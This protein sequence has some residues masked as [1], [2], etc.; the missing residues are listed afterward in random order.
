LEEALRRARAE[1]D[2]YVLLYEDEGTFYRQP[3]QGWLW[4]WM[5]RSQPKMRY[6][7]AANRRLRMVAMLNARTGA[8]H[9][10]DMDRVSALRLARTVSR[11]SSWYPDAETIYLGWDN[12][13]VHTH[14]RVAETLGRQSRVQVLPLPTYA[15]WLNPTEKVWRRAK[16]RLTHA[17]PW[18]DD[19]RE[20][21][22][23]VCEEFARLSSG[24]DELLRYVGLS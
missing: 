18:S 15:P 12:W 21:R 10:E 7:H 3:T 17:H 16:Q 20:F 9:S 4:G 1:L 22:R 11:I 5:G 19:F 24:S 14:P 23:Q 8:V 6:S 2:R 13:P